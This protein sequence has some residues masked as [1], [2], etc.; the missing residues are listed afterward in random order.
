MGEYVELYK[1]YQPRVFDDLVGQDTVVR[2]LRADILESTVPA[3]YLFT[4]LHGAGKTSAAMLVAKALNCTNRTPA[5]ADPCNRCEDCVM[6]DEGTHPGVRY[7][8]MAN[9]GDA[10]SVQA[11]LDEAKLVQPGKQ[12]IIICDEVHRLS[13]VALD[14]FLIPLENRDNS[15]SAKFIF[16][17]TEGLVASPTV[18]SRII[19]YTFTPVPYKT[20]LRLLT[21]IVTREKL[22][23]DEGTLMEAAK[24]GRGSIRDALTTLE[25][26][27]RTGAP[28]NTN[29]T[30]DKLLEAL[31]N[32]SVPSILETTNTM[33]DTGEDYT[34]TLND[35]MG[36][37]QNM[38]LLVHN[39]PADLRG[40]LPFNG[41]KQKI[42]WLLFGISKDTPTIQD[43]LC[44]LLG[45][46]M[47][48]Y[49]NMLTT[50]MDNKIILN[51]CLLECAQHLTTNP[52]QNQ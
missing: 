31:G 52:Q 40:K 16:C 45:I 35:L 12:N 19:E 7:E 17:T 28:V 24:T 44:T 9:R 1:K 8:S 26:L 15:L 18:R 42:L 41:D 30:T 10:A 33:E 46:M 36:A 5:V 38:L 25:K 23:V 34:D 50:P 14:K 4:G 3:A 2:A 49:T 39:T 32:R 37:T 6:I 51:M 13:K 48:H 11:L 47:R 22:P 20:I 43:T 27:Y 29:S 21:R